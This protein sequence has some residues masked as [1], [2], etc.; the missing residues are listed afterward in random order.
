MSDNLPQ[1]HT[2]ALPISVYFKT[3]GVLVALMAATVYVAE[4]VHLGYIGNNIVA[5]TIAVVKAVCVILF[6]MHVKYSSRLTWFWCITAFLW[7]A[8]LFVLTLA[9][10]HTRGWQPVPGWRNLDV[11]Y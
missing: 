9:D 3:F 10:Y 4:Y 1:D 5:M 6:F 11:T 7:L 8:V 2:H